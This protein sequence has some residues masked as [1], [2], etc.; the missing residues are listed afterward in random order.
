MSARA[1]K[2]AAPKDFAAPE[3]ALWSRSIRALRE[4]GLWHDSDTDA[5]ERY[6]RASAS[7]RLAAERIKDEG[8]TS[9]GSMGQQVISPA[10]T[11]ERQA[12]LDADKLAGE[13]GL[14]PSARKRLG[15]EVEHDDDDTLSGDIERARRSLRLVEGGQNGR[16]KRSTI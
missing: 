11:L 7:A 13:L 6:C 1:F 5:V 15:V 2:P 14:T 16:S 12:R 8:Y 9:R 10:A 4:L 3:R